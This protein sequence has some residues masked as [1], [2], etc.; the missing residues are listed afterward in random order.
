[1]KKFFYIV[2]LKSLNDLLTILY[3]FLSESFTAEIIN[4]NLKKRILTV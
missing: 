1:M 3:V 2:T 4:K